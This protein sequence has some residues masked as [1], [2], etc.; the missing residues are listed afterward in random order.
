[1]LSRARADL[2]GGDI[3]AALAAVDA[4]PPAAREAMAAWAEGATARSA[5]EA[6]LADWR[7]DTAAQ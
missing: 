6:A 7:I 2:L 4:L 1:V 5:A 3:E